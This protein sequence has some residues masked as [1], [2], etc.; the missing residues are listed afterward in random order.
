[1]YRQITV[2]ERHL[3]AVLRQLGYPAA[4][5]ARVLGRHRSTIGREVHRNGAHSDGRYRVEL[6]DWY[7]RGRRSR[8]R[9]NRRFA[10]VVGEYRQ[11][12]QDRLASPVGLGRAEEGAVASRKALRAA[13]RAHHVGSTGAAQAASASRGGEQR[14]K[15]GAL[16]PADA[17]AKTGVS[18]GRRDRQRAG[19][20]TVR[21]E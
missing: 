6:A 9:R 4:A 1:M 13:R 11:A 7:A 5:I 16:G 8:S 3:L 20:P 10:A 19:A 15:E 21:F 18:D 14:P 17:H 12:V 2:E